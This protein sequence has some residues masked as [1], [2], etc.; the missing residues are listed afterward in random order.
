[1]WLL[2]IELRTSGRAVGAFNYWAISPV[3]ILPLFN[4][5]SGYWN[6]VP[7]DILDPGFAL[8]LVSVGPSLLLLLSSF[9]VCVCVCVCVCVYICVYMHTGQRLMPLFSFIVP[10][11]T[12][13]TGT[14]WN[15]ILLNQLVWL[16]SKPL[17]PCF[18]QLPNT[19]IIDAYC[20]SRLYLTRGMKSGPKACVAGTLLNGWF[21]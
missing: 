11:L 12:V 1:M 7:W 9:V 10:Y 18:L 15:W 4:C 20:Y 5:I 14:H 19:R 6:L 17:V 8:M 13:W 21:L 3:P 16:D 2:G